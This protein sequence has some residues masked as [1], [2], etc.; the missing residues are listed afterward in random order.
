MAIR[1]FYSCGCGFRSGFLQSAQ[2]H[3]NSAGHVVTITGSLSPDERVVDLK[4]I[5]KNAER[6]ARE[7]EILRRARHRGL[8]T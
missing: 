3:S 4:K 6:K 2:D 1:L 8:L 5:E 7:A